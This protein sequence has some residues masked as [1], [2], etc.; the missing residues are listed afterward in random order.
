MDPMFTPVAGFAPTCVVPSIVK[1]FRTKVVPVGMTSVKITLFAFVL[2]VPVKE[3][4]YVSVSPI[5][6]KFLSTTFVIVTV[7]LFT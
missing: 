2:P 3:T 6:A 1:L 5:S 7:A 4:V